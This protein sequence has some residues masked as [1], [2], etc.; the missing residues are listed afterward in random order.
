VWLYNQKRFSGSPTQG[1]QFLR[2]LSQRKNVLV[3]FGFF[4]LASTALYLLITTVFATE[5]LLLVAVSQTFNFHH[6][7][8]DSKI[9]KF[10]SPVLG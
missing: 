6:Y 9:W 2:A 10:R 8:V 3:Y 7:I 1:A 5:P 4:W